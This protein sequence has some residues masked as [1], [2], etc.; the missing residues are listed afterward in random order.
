L[1]QIFANLRMAA[2]YAGLWHSPALRAVETCEWIGPPPCV[3]RQDWSLPS[4]S[5]ALAESAPSR[6]KPA[7]ARPLQGEMLAIDPRTPR[8][9]QQ[10][11]FALDSNGLAIR[12]VVWRVDGSPLAGT[13]G[14]SASWELAPGA[15]R[16]SARV[17]VEGRDAPFAL[18][19]IPFSVLG[20]PSLED[21]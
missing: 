2:P 15:H 1:R 7:I 5:G 14:D 17:W 16:V 13:H 20:N 12:R 11:H 9:S 21:D 10:F 6:A 19:P 8:A 4:G 3:R 18:G